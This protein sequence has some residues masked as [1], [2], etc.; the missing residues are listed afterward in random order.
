[1]QHARCWKTGDLKK[2]V[3]EKYLEIDGI[4]EEMLR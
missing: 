4:L 2:K 1:M 3:E